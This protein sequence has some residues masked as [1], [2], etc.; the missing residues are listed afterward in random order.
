MVFG[1]NY[2][3]SHLIPSV[4]EQRFYKYRGSLTKHMALARI[5]YLIEF[6][7]LVALENFIFATNFA[8]TLLN[9]W[10]AFNI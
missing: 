2:F 10:K 3:I 6:I 4:N 1:I 9:F 5:T 7:K 8:N